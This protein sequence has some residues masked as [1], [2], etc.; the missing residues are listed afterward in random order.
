MQCYDIILYLENKKK[1]CFDDVN[2]RKQNTRVLLGSGDE[3]GVGRVF[4]AGQGGSSEGQGKSE[5]KG[6]G[7]REVL[8]DCPRVQRG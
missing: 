8:C 5:S 4:L 2:Y 3:E 1:D 7:Q 6:V